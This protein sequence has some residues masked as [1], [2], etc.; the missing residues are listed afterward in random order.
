MTR[1]FDRDADGRKRHMQSLAP[2]WHHERMAERSADSP[3]TRDLDADAR[4]NERARQSRLAEDRARSPE[5]RLHMT[6]SAS[7]TLLRL[8]GAARADGSTRT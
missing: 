2:P 4:A 3:A 7:V 1:R 6:L 8:A 5:E